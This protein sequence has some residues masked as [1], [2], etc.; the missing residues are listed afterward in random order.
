MVSKMPGNQLR[1]TETLAS[2][3]SSQPGVLKEGPLP[4]PGSAAAWFSQ[5]RQYAA[6][7][8][9]QAAPGALLRLQYSSQKTEPEAS[10]PKGCLPAPSFANEKDILPLV[11]FC[12]NMRW[13]IGTSF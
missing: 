6:Q 10:V 8:L 9:T 11:S 12:G 4:G 7:S 5:Q 13:E 1:Q 3:R 2:A